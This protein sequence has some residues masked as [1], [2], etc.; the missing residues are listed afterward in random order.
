MLDGIEM[1]IVGRPRSPIVFIAPPS[2]IK[3]EEQSFSNDPSVL[4]DLGYLLRIGV[5]LTTLLFDQILLRRWIWE[6]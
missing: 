6:N 4:G 2:S 5:A 1:S 3:D